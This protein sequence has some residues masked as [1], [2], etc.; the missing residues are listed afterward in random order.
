MSHQ[1]IL[2][3]GACS[4]LLGSGYYGN[5]FTPKNKLLK[6]TNVNHR[7]NEFIHLDEIRKIKNYQNYY[8]IP[9]ELECIIYPSDKFYKYL[10]EITKEFEMS[11]FGSNLCCNYIDYA[12]NIDVLNTMEQLITTN[13]S[14]IWKSYSTILRFT[15]HIV[16]G[17][18]YLHERQLCHL[19]I[20]PENIV[21]N[22]QKKTFKIIDFG[23]CSKEPFADYTND[24]KGTPGYFPKFFPNEKITEW[25]PKIEANDMNLIG[26]KVPMQYDYHLVYKIDSYCLGRVLYALIY[27]YKHYSTTM[28]ISFGERKNRKKLNNVMNDLLEKNVYERLT[29]TDIV[30]KYL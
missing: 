18:K 15:Y 23:F 30:N 16:N 6:I 9:D 11:I 19:D 2:K 14:V 10:Q 22:T 28:C 4:I 21:V 29:I 13:Y 24:I 26:N 20:K 8:S 17:L 7:H 1:E 25:F 5:Y 27:I 12:G 3:T